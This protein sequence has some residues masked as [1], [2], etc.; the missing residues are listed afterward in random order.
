MRGVAGLLERGVRA[1]AAGWVSLGA[2]LVATWPLAA[3]LSTRVPLGTE[4][5]TTV[6]VFSLW[7]LWWTADRI[8][9]G[10]AGFLDAPFFY[11]NHGVTT[12]SEP[13]PLLGALVAPLWSL[14]ASPAL[15]YNIALLLLLTLN[16]VFM[17]RLVRALSAPVEAAL[18]GSVIAV[19]LPFA[20]DVLGVLPNL[21]LFGMLWTLDGL[22]RFG[23]T[24]SAGWAL[25]SA[26]GL[27]AMYL[28]FQQYA[29]FFAPLAL[30]GALVALSLQRFR[31]GASARLVGAWL[32]AVAVALPLALP[33]VRRHQDLG[34]GRPAAL[35]HALSARPADFFTRP[36][37]ALLHVPR[38]DPADTAGLFP[39][40]L[41][42]GLALAGAAVGMRD[43]RHR[44]WAALL[45]G[46]AVFGVLLASGLNLDL[47]GWRPFGTLRAVVPGFDEV[48]SPYRAA[49]VFQI[50]LPPLAA[51]ALARIPR[52]S[53][54]GG[55]VV[56]VAL[57]LLAAVENLAVP[58]PLAH[59]PN[60]ARTAWTAWL[61]GQPERRVVAHVPFPGGVGVS[62]YEVETWRMFRQIDHHRPIVNGYSGFFPVVR[63]RKGPAY[64]AYLAFQLS[65]AREFP[66]YQLLCVL[67]KGIGVDTLVAD[68]EWAAARRGRLAAF[69]GF[70]RP[71]YADADVEI[72]ALRTPPGRCRTG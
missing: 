24:G 67:S 30:A 47:A 60:S 29:L 33:T 12:Y 65:M 46:G 7:N 16:G 56:V 72:Y 26:A 63:T 3:H 20:A 58:V 37:T 6:P 11:P 8:P 13:M 62:D 51:L 14:G 1:T 28:T 31:R 45:A 21:A 53:V 43:S 23:R 34:F 66:S 18:L 61:R 52:R 36:A 22:V 9:H 27:L 44:R 25:W 57:G 5:E 49:A 17:Y 41:L 50:C 38:P 59:V 4:H 19:A 64:P 54:R 71:A 69:R 2:A 32:V 39:G 48:R 15:V 70:I 55:A 68:R 10:F 35:V 40:A 42:L